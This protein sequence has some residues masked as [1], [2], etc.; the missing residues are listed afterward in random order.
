MIAS[1][2]SLLKS[3]LSLAKHLFQFPLRQSGDAFHTTCDGADLCHLPMGV[4]RSSSPSEIVMIPH[5]VDEI[6]S[7]PLSDCKQIL[8]A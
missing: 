7:C 5:L 2:V 3:K 6:R 8:Q 1:H 4:N